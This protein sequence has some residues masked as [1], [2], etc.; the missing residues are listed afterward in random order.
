MHIR[1]IP[2]EDF[3]GIYGS[4]QLRADPS[5]TRILTPDVIQLYSASLTLD[6][7]HP[8]REPCQI[9][10]NGLPDFTGLGVVCTPLAPLRGMWLAIQIVCQP[11]KYAIVLGDWVGF[12]QISNSPQVKTNCPMG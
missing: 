8:D 4:F 6:P 7:E 12:W 10:P 9:Y 1:L 11:N 5:A 3:A 2:D